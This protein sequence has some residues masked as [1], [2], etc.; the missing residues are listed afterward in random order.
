[1]SNKFDDRTIEELQRVRRANNAVLGCARILNEHN[2]HDG[3]IPGR[4]GVFLRLDAEQEG[5]L[6][7]A[8]ETCSRFVDELFESYFDDRGVAWDREHLPDIR[9]EA[10]AHAA[11]QAGEISYPEYEKIVDKPHSFNGGA[12]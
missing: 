3:S 8:I 11:M 9:I 10:E 6:V 12:S 1:M 4:L 5:S 7:F 2:S